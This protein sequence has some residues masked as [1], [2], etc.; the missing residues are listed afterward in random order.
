MMQ[1]PKKK[2]RH[3]SL[4]GRIVEKVML[5][6]FKNVKR[7]KGAAGIDKVSLGMYE[8]NLTENLDSLMRELK[9]DTYQPKPLR[10]KLIPKGNGQF[11][12]LGIPSVKDSRG[13]RGY[14]QRHPPD[15]RKAVSSQF[16]RV[17]ARPELHHR[18][19]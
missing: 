12:P 15:L 5:K 8:A 16:P 10:R 1:V 3:H 4:T 9:T 7:N 17:Q 11:R 14:P 13:A 6:A 18:H 19:E 2:L